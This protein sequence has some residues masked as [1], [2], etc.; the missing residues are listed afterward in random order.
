MYHTSFWARP[1]LQFDVF[2][3]WFVSQGSR[4]KE[5]ITFILVG[6]YLKMIFHVPTIVFI[7]AIIYTR[8]EHDKSQYTFDETIQW[9]VHNSIIHTAQ[10]FHFCRSCRIAKFIWLRSVHSVFSSTRCISLSL[11]HIGNNYSGASDKSP[12]Y[13]RSAASS[14]RTWLWRQLNR[15]AQHT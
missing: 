5:L 6:Q 14:P 1:F 4:R 10:N 9:N 7:N 12:F 3:I 11:W 2:F 8:F 13:V 15:P